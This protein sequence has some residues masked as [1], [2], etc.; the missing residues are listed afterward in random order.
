MNEEK[1][2]KILKENF[3][4]KEE[5]DSRFREMSSRFNEIDTH[6]E[7]MDEKLDDLKASS[8]A[9]DN[10]LEKHPIPR[11]E[12]IEKHLDLPTYAHS[13]VEEE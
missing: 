3:S 4:T 2:I 13:V 10:I 12:R 7:K 1:L 5:T 6:L 11:I 9:F 8:S